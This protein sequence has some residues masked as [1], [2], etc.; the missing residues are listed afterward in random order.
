MSTPASSLDAESISR[1]FG[2]ITFFAN[3][4]TESRSSASD[5][6]NAVTGSR[7]G[8]AAASPPVENM[9]RIASGWKGVRRTA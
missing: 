2:A 9:A 8:A 6:L 5:S 3:A 7:T 1:T 4:A